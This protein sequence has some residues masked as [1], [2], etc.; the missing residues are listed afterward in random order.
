MLDSNQDLLRKSLANIHQK[1]E[2]LAK[3]VQD[4]SKPDKRMHDENAE[5]K[6]RLVPQSSKHSLPGLM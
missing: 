4:V 6:A 3:I 5:D 1:T 2:A